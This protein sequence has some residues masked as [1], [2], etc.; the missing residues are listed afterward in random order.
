M[1]Q[2]NPAMMMQAK[3]R[4][5]YAR[6]VNSYYVFSCYGQGQ[7]VFKLFNEAAKVAPVKLLER[8]GL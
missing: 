5:P 2:V 3:E 8:H 6:N 4:K 1:L 7:R